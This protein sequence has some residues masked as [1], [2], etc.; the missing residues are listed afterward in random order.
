[1]INKEIQINDEMISVLL[2]KEDVLQYLFDCWMKI[3]SNENEILIDIIN[4]SIQNIIKHNW[5]WLS[6]NYV[7]DIYY[8]VK[9]G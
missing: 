9:R 3:D 6:F 7:I 1:M 2:E 5:W 4:E 8:F